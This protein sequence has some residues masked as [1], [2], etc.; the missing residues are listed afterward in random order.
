M[1]INDRPEIDWNEKSLFIRPYWKPN[2]LI[3]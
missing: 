3:I 1:D 2:Q